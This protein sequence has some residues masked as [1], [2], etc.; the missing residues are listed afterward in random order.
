MV[1]RISAKP[2]TKDSVG[3]QKWLRRKFAVAKVEFLVFN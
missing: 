2:S 3:W 1:N